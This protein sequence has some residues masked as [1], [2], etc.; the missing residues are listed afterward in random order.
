MVCK[1]NY[2]LKYFF[3]I[4]RFYFQLHQTQ[5]KWILENGASS[6]MSFFYAKTSMDILEDVLTTRDGGTSLNQGL[7]S[8]VTKQQPHRLGPSQL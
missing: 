7:L 1:V 2:N 8:I 6:V 4:L 3:L 5:M